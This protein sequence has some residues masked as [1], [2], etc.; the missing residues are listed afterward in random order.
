MNRYTATGRLTRDPEMRTTNDGT[1]VC[2]LRLA[3]DRMGRGDQTGYIDVATF[4]K[5]AEACGQVLAKGWLV[6]V[7]GRLQYSEWEATDGAKRSGHSIVGH[8]TFLAAPKG[9]GEDVPDSPP[10][11]CADDIP[12]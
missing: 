10:V 4:G 12:F 2:S 3:I 6:A 8:V 9:S 7:D 11:I 5:P 1:A